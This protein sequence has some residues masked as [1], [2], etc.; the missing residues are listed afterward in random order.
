MLMEVLELDSLPKATKVLNAIL[1]TIKHALLRHEKVYIKGFGT[2]KIVERTHRPTPNSIVAS[3]GRCRPL[4][5]APDLSYYTPRRVLIFQ[6]SLPFMA[7]LNANSPNY[8]EQRTQQL[9]RP[10]ANR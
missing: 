2:F 8:K 7:M 1:D 6:P 10:H 5:C 4:A 9:W 3:G